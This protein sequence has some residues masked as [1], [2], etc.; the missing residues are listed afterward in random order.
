MLI[1]IKRRRK[2]LLGICWNDMGDILP[3]TSESVRMD[4]NPFSSSNGTTVPS[5]NSASNVDGDVYD[6]DDSYFVLPN[7]NRLSM[8]LPAEL[9]GA[10]PLIDRFQVENFLRAMQ[11]QINSAGKRVFFSRKSIGPA[12]NEKF[13]LE[14]MLCF[15]KDPI[16][17]SLL[18]IN[19]D[20]VS[21]SVKIFQMILKYMG[22]DSSDKLTFLSLD[23]R[24]ELITKLYK[25][26]L[27]RSELR[28]EFF[29]QIS[30]QTRNNPDRSCLV[31]AW[32]LMYLFSSSMPPS[33]DIGA[34]LSEYVHNVVQGVKTDPEVQILALNTL[35][36]LKRSVKAGPRL[37]I[38]AREEIEALL[39]GKKLT[40]IVFF[41]DETF[42]EITYDM[43][44]TVGDAVQVLA[45]NI[46]CGRYCFRNTDY[47]KNKKTLRCG[48]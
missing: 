34:Y 31:K 41:L 42:E 6:C 45:C 40:T 43:T 13:T 3:K 7:S 14:D 46:I 12:V 36:S 16:P 11:K 1:K 10:I 17:T 24:I 22:I 37:T 33:M 29:A 15:Q 44:T 20:L 2:I 9:A 27:K 19:S 48:E 32:E 35:N 18:K 28:D 26:T 8:S 47:I 39:I 25:Q 30:K 21:R 5:Q 38:P 23:E 4:Q